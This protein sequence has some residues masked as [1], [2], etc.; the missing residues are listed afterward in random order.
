L[1]PEAQGGMIRKTYASLAGSV[2]KTFLRVIKGSPVRAYGG[3]VPSMFIYP[4]GSKIH[5][6][7]MDN[8][9]RVLS[10]ERDF[11]Y[12]C[13]TEELKESDWETLL[14]RASGR[15]AVV[16][17]AQLFGDCNPGG[18]KH[19]IRERSKRTLRLLRSLHKD[20]PTIYDANGE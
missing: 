11:I 6:G 19:W 4:N 17:H 12:T 8:P 9:D 1:I 14:T 10:S 7:G 16:A 20:N 13:Q 18:S 5:L 2:V 15:G 3:E